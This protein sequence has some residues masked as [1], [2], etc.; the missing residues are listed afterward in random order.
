ME[1]VS[2]DYGFFVYLTAK[3]YI[4]WPFGTFCAHLVYFSPVLVCS[5]EKNL[6]TLVCSQTFTYSACELEKH[7]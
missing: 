2:I 1:D 4:L 3:L 6:A 5:T 7:I